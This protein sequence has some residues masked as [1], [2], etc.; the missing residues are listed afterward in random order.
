MTGVTILTVKWKGQDESSK[1]LGGI[2]RGFKE[3]EV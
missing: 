1:Y 2:Y 3:A